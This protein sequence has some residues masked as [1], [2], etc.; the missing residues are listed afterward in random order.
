MTVKITYFV[1][2][3][4]IDNQQGISTGQKPGQLSELGIKQSQELPDKIGDKEFAAIFS[5]N[6]KRAVASAQISFGEK[7]EIIEDERL[8]EC[9]YGKLNQAPEAEVNYSDHIK[10]PFPNGESLQQ[11][12]DRVEIF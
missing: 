8:R 6:L 1:H 5:S 12:E 9:D 2:G 11:V 4:T 3:T 10:Q 7:Y